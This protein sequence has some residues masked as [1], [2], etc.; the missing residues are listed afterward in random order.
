V[1]DII[2]KVI[3]LLEK[4]K[5]LDN[6][7]V[8]FFSDNGYHLGQFCVAYDKR[9]PYE[10]DIHVPMFVRGPNIKPNTIIDDITLNIDLGPSFVYMATGKS[11]PYMDGQPIFPDSPNYFP[12]VD[13]AVE[14]VGEADYS[15]CSGMWPGCCN[16][17]SH[18]F[19]NPFQRWC[20]DSGNNTYG[21]LRSINSYSN[22]LYCEF[23][24]DVGFREYYDL[25]R[26]PYEQF[27]IAIESY[28]ITAPLSARMRYLR[29]CAGR[30]SCN[31]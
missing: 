20:I 26:D 19:V 18:Q 3:A 12:R 8:V 11:V 29:S 24:D 1:D 27:N 25:R 14:Y 10:T 7:Y 28:N 4:Y 16:L 2:G 13:F 21:C 6:A 15:N 31:Q 5:R 22:N 30:A 23:Q 17:T 9:L